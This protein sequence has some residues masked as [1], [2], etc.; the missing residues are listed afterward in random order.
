M[1]QQIRTPLVPLR[2]ISSRQV[3]GHSRVQ[4]SGSA[5]MNLPS[6]R[7]PASSPDGGG[8]V[9]W[10]ATGT[11]AEGAVSAHHI[12]PRTRSGMW[13]WRLTSHQ[14]EKLSL[15][16]TFFPS[17]SSYSIGQPFIKV[18]IALWLWR[19]APSCN[20]C[21]PPSWG[22]ELHQHRETSA[23]FFPHWF[24]RW[25]R[26]FFLRE[27]ETPQSRLATTRFYIQW[28][29]SKCLNESTCF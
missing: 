21:L 22:W 18:P 15:A 2:I 17:I 24:R 14:S 16:C 8:K 6:A 25:T 19:S 9:R 12:Q 23:C 26:T 11:A 29:P 1:L 7:I 10:K 5:G 13:N 28:Q 4:R 3:S 27:W 20:F